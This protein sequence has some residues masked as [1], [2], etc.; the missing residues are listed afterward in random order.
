MTREH[1]LHFWPDI[2]KA[3][4][5][6]TFGSAFRSPFEAFQGKNRFRY[7]CCN[8]HYIDLAINGSS[9]IGHISGSFS[10]FVGNVR[11]ESIYLYDHDGSAHFT[12]KISGCLVEHGDG[13]SVCTNCSLQ[14]FLPR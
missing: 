5:L 4:R 8:D 10:H 14:G 12:Y 7:A 9:F 3:E 6:K 2:P 11:G 13:H 1:A